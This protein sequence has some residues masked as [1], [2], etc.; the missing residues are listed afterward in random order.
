MLNS[1]E[2]TA[3]VVDAFEAC[4]IDYMVVGA[5]SS[6]AYSIGRSTKDADF[7][8]SLRAGQLPELMQ[9]LG[10]EFQLDRQLQLEM[11]TGSKRNVITYLPTKFQ[12]EI[13]RLNDQD[14]H[15]LERF[16]RRYRK[17]LNE[18]NRLVWLP[19]VED[20][21]IQKLRWLTAHR[22]RRCRLCPVCQQSEN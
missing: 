14:E 9:H 2:A 13:F 17:L 7:V 3:A 5:Y 10:T 8:V 11:L 18:I 4:R 21:V 1:I 16:R 22:P 6:N 20:V 19:T 12:L 15:H